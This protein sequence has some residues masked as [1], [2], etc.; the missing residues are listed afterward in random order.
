MPRRKSSRINS[1]AAYGDSSTNPSIA[2]STSPLRSL[3]ADS[4]Y[5]DDGGGDVPEEHGEAEDLKRGI[6]RSKADAKKAQHRNAQEEEKR[7]QKANWSIY[8]A[9]EAIY[10]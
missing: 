5:Y 10:L 7:R 6:A 1:D 3:A 8:Q 9:T 2:D 4:G